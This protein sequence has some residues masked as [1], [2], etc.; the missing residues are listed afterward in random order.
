MG[1]FKKFIEEDFLTG[2]QLNSPTFKGYVEVFRNPT[3]RE[4]D[5]IYKDSYDNGVRIGIDKKSNIYVWI[6]DVLHDTMEKQLKT[7]FVI[8]LSYTNN[9]QDMFLSAEDDKKN[10]DKNITKILLKRLKLI[11]PSIKD[12]KESAGKLRIVYSYK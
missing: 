11:F 9:R 8:K 4:I 2:I 1:K 7:K 10:F 12:I 5:S 3:K 6:E